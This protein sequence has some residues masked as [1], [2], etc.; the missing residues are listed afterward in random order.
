MGANASDYIAG[1]D[2]EEMRRLELQ[3]RVLK[4]SLEAV[5][6]CAGLQPG[7]RVLDVGCGAGDVSLLAAE[8]VGSMGEVVGIDIAPQPLE[9][10]RRRAEAMGFSHTR[11][12]KCALDAVPPERQF[13]VV[14][15]RLVVVHQREPEAFVKSMVA[16]LRP[17]GLLICIEPEMIAPQVLAHPPLPLFNRAWEW[18]LSAVTSLGYR[19]HQG[20]ELPPLLRR[21]GL[22]VEGSV[23]VGPVSSS[24]EPGAE[25]AHLPVN[26]LR[27]LLPHAE[28]LGVVKRA[29]VD[30]DTLAERISAEACDGEGSLV[31]MLMVGVWARRQEEGT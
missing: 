26:I 17:G 29:D 10:A 23:L 27:V 7:M 13:D 19:P 15:E 5:L 6:R 2:D 12:E 20:M 3:S 25:A 14:V 30:I 1:H 8:L 9:W 16:H 4:S 21:L 11:F 24:H 18:L 22:L 31:P 28:R